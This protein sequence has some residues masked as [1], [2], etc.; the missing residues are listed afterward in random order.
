MAIQAS[1]VSRQKHLKKM[2]DIQQDLVKSIKRIEG[3]TTKQEELEQESSITKKK[4]AD[5]QRYQK[6]LEEREVKLNGELISLLEKQNN[7]THERVNVK[8]LEEK[9]HT[10]ESQV[11][12][13]D[14]ENRVL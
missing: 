14:S 11:G 12:E 7:G 4:I 8:D 13:I 5:Q 2:N 3:L 9:V 10:L 1:E 6:E